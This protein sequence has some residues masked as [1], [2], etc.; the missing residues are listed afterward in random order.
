MDE[1]PQAEP[2]DEEALFAPFGGRVAYER[3]VA[4]CLAVSVV[5]EGLAAQRSPPGAAFRLV[6]PRQYGAMLRRRAAVDKVRAH[7]PLLSSH[8]ARAERPAA[9][10]TADAHKV[11]AAYGAGTAARGRAVRQSAAGTRGSGGGARCFARATAA[12]CPA[13]HTAALRLCFLGEYAVVNAPR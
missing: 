12:S 9:S 10:V 4:R 5:A 2:Q 7:V 13:W 8:A 3:E 1:G 11:A 6:H